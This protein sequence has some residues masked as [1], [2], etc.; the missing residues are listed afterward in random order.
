MNPL[1]PMKRLSNILAALLIVS[2]GALALCRTG[3]A[4]PVDP[5][6]LY[7][8]NIMG[9]QGWFACPNDGAG[10]GYGHWENAQHV[11]NIDM[12]PD[13]S[14]LDP[15]ELCDSGWVARDGK[16]V[17]LF[18]DQNPKTVDRQFGWMETYGLDGVALQRFATE[19]SNPRALGAGDHVLSNVRAA[20]ERHGRVYFIMYDLSGMTPDKLPTV[21]DDWK[22]LIGEGVTRD[23]SY[24]RH[25]GRPVLALWGIGFAGRPLTPEVTE[26]FLSQLRA[27]SAAAGGITI[28]GGVPTWWRELKGDAS[29]D[30][31][32][33]KIWPEIDVISPWTVG[34]FANDGNADGYRS[35]GLTPD[36]A[37]AKKINVDY[38]PVVFPGY[39]FSNA[40]LARHQPDKA[41]PNQIPRRCG[42]FY[43]HQVTNAI[44]SGARM[45]YT[46]M[47]DEVDEGTAMFKIAPQA[48]NS[49]QNPSFVTLDADGC[50]ATSDFYLRLAAEAAATLRAHN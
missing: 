19:L 35:Q 7:G 48:A 43:D 24:Q 22:R 14:E 34:R 5:S 11:P 49:P 38:M 44:N 50:H 30:P 40:S 32:W 36:V 29:N 39:S 27:A 37:Y 21:V 9:F 45:V 25:K 26:A 16:P 17:K 31:A 13:V 41:I 15:S 3:R 12:L 47:F 20:A 8:K 33:A 28:L 23:R 46:A 10:I 18:S 1:V 42:D 6:T 4:A 2:A